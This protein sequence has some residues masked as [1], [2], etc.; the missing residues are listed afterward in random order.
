M[1]L[2]ETGP[3]QH[4][5]RPPFHEPARVNGRRAVHEN[6]L[7]ALGILMRLGES[8]LVDDLGRIE[9]HKVGI[10]PLRDTTAPFQSH[11][12]GWQRCHFAHRLLQ[13]HY[14]FLAHIMPQ[15]AWECA[16]PPWVRMA[17]ARLGEAPVGAG[18]GEGMPHDAFHVA[19]VEHMVN[20]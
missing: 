11:P 2:A 13:L 9:D 12:C 7:D 6:K 19:F 10:K 4:L 15:H 16:V 17:A 1:A 5:S 14:F 8:R 18:H 3:P 20:A